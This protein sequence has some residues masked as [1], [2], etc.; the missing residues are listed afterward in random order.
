[1]PQTQ[2][3][4]MADREGDLY[5][6]HDAANLGPPNLHTLVRAQHNRNLDCHH[7]LW[8]FMES[9]PVGE[10]RTIDVPR[11]RGAA[12][13][14]ATLEIRWS[15]VSIQAPQAGVKKGWPSLPL[16]AVWVHEPHPPEGTEPIQWMLLTDMPVADATRAWEIVGWYG[17]RWGIEEWHRVLKTG[18]NAEGR[19]FKSAE[20]LTRV[21][22]FDL[23]VAWRILACV[24]LG[25]ALPQLSAATL[26]TRDE[27]EVLCAAQ[28]KTPAQTP[29][30]SPLPKPTG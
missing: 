7:K 30:R 6:L 23:I 1:M 20:H 26:Y 15:S 2:V 4:V 24:K 19:E 14:K 12:A 29:L 22:A 16:H 17:R 10:P 13:R 25:R 3:V 5:E 18:C 27:L 8:T 28:K 11:R 9:L 21:L